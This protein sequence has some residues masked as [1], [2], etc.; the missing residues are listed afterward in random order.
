MRPGIRIFALTLCVLASLEPASARDLLAYPDPD[1][2]STGWARGGGPLIVNLLTNPGFDEDLTGWDEEIGPYPVA[3]STDNELGPGPS[4]SLKVTNLVANSSANV[5]AGCVPVAPGDRLVYGAAVAAEGGTGGR[6]RVR[7]R[8]YSAAGCAGSSGV[9]FT[10]LGTRFPNST[11]GA[12]QGT[13]EVPAGVASVK[14]ELFINTGSA[15]PAAV[16]FDNAFLVK[17]STCVRTGNTLCLAEDRFR[18]SAIWQKPDG[19][20]GWARVEPLTADSGYLWFFK[21]TNIE[22]VVKVLDGCSF[23]DRFWVFAA[24]LTNVKVDLEVTDT[25]TGERW[26]SA[27]PLGEAFQPV[28]DTNAFATCEP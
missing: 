14:F 19:S 8:L 22:T 18:V 21:S 9:S 20:Q 24:G 28:Q 1:H 16:Y 4:G 27:N 25:L 2:T 26:E 15:P 13:L 6:G 3:W 7:L 23:S 17:H 10:E 5:S 11:W 12:A